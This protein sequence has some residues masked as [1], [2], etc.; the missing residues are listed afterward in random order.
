M[1][2]ERLKSPRARLFVAL[3]LPDEIREE[4]VAWQQREL[5]DPALRVVPAQNLHIT[6][7]FLDWQAER[8][9][10]P[11][12]EL[13]Q[14]LPL[15]APRLRFEPEPVGKGSS[16]RRPSLFALD[17]PSEG[18][19]AVHEEIAG[20][21]VAAGFYE[22]E[23]RPFW[24]H[25]TVA[26]VKGERRGSRKPRAVETFPGPLPERLTVHPFDAVRVSLYRSNLR[27]QGAEYVLLAQTE[28]PQNT[29]DAAKR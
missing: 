9:I 20:R 24:S 19:V 21:L 23:N 27:P 4:V 16:R 2:K 7:V 11:I 15:A 3:D 18:A 12:A 26:R 25:V 17:A 8:D 5:V 28:L 14:N 13:L 29:P 1:T 10:E 6:L 22:R